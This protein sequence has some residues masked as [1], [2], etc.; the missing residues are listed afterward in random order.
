MLM[1]Q[2]PPTKLGRAANEPHFVP[3]PPRL[4]DVTYRLRNGHC[5]SISMISTTKSGA[6]MR[7]IDILS[8]TPPRLIDA[9]LH[10]AD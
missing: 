9:K 1:R 7:V 8:N 5:G 3:R 4:W 6:L 10:S 2:I